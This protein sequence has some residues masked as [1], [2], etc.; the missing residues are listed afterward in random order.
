MLPLLHLLTSMGTLQKEE[1]MY[2]RV[3]SLSEEPTLSGSSHKINETV[4]FWM[5]MVAD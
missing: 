2:V 1:T 3:R 5:P 4:H